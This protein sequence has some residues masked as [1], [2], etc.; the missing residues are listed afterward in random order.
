MEF[1]EPKQMEITVFE[2]KHALNEFYSKH[3]REEEIDENN[4]VIK[5]FDETKKEFKLSFAEKTQNEEKC[6]TVF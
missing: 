6:H 2:S 3:S 5:N 4:P 1:N